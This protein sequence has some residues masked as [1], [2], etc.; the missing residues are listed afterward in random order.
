M[1]F[2]NELSSM[3]G[4]SVYCYAGDNSLA[5]FFPESWADREMEVNLFSSHFDLRKGLDVL[6]DQ[7]VAKIMI[8]AKPEI[9]RLIRLAKEDFERYTIVRSAPHYLEVSA[10]GVSKASAIEAICREAGISKEDVYTFGDSGNDLEMIA[11]F[12]GVA[13]GNA[14]DEVKAAAQF[15]TKN[16]EECGVAF[17]LREILRLI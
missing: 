13:M 4:V 6:A 12:H 14:T 3:E 10:K 8:A 1:H 15:V 7:G 11:N 5:S 9:S 2:K 16:C 17:A